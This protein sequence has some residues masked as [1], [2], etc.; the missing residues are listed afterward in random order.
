MPC[1]HARND[2]TNCTCDLSAANENGRRVKTWFAKGTPMRVL[3]VGV[4]MAC[5]FPVSATMVLAATDLLPP[6]PHQLAAKP[7]GE[8]VDLDKLP[9]AV[10]D[11]VQKEMP[12]A[13]LTQALK[14]VNGNFYLTDV[15]S[16]KKE[17]TLT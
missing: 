8:A 9:K 3:M 5:F 7:A 4:S 16:G 13:R 17:F 11:A 14:L 10:V 6:V 15:K 12:G 2:F 1:L